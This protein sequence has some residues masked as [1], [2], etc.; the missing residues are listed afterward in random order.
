MNIALRR[1][2]VIGWPLAHSLSPLL[3]Q[4]WMRKAGLPEN[5][6]EVMPT[7]PDVL[8]GRLRTLASAGFIGCNVTIPHKESVFS[9]LKK[10]GTLDNNASRLQAVNTILIDG[11]G[12][13]HGCNS[14]GSGFLASLDEQAPAWRDCRHASTGA[15]VVLGAGG[16][17]RAILAALADSG[18]KSVFVVNRTKERAERLLHDLQITEAR[19]FGTDTAELRNA[20]RNARLLVN[21]TNLGMAGACSWREGIGSAPAEFLAHVHSDAIVVDIVYTPLQTEFLQA[22]RA[23]DLACVDGLGML[24]YQAV[25]CFESWFGVCP[26][27][28]P[29]LRSILEQALQTPEATR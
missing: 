24:L 16:A 17:A 19:V 22:A 8:F 28:V 29:A 10:H 5:L 20:M 25:P 4:F 23:R 14:D 18:M 11:Q 3:H 21:A 15:V 27:V 9:F 26:K 1:V 12:S 7:P 2:G 13:M 6:Y